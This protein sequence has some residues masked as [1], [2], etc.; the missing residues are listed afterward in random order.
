M[1]NSMV[2]LLDALEANMKRYPEDQLSIYRCLVDVGKRHDDYIEKLIPTLLKL[3]KR[4]LPREANVE[5][6]LCM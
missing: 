2:V 3:D 1:Q 6:N 4:Y 5:D